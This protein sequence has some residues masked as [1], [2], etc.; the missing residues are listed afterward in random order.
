MTISSQYAL[1]LLR[2][3]ITLCI[4]IIFTVRTQ[5]M[6]SILSYA[7]HASPTRLLCAATDMFICG[8]NLSVSSNAMY[9]SR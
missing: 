8:Y 3:F 6:L 2:I 7:T 4:Y 1:H 5:R 9:E